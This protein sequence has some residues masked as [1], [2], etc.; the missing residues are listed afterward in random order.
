MDRYPG[1]KVKRKELR[2][3]RRRP[4]PQG[5]KLAGDTWRGLGMAEKNWKKLEREF[6]RDVGTTRIPV[7]GERAGSDFE[8]ARHCY[9][10]KCRESIPSC[11]LIPPLHGIRRR[12]PKTI[13]AWL[14]G[15]VWTAGRK[16]KVGVLVL[17]QMGT[18]RA[19]GKGHTRRNGSVAVLRLCD[20]EGL[21]GAFRPDEA[22]TN[23]LADD[24]VVLVMR[25]V[26]WMTV[27]P[28][29]P[30][31]WPAPEPVAENETTDDSSDE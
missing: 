6:A 19:A 26:V 27:D 10:L 9:Q 4:V 31:P 21:Y 1:G 11:L 7:T 24:T 12:L 17:R 2:W 22:W 18:K 29:G 16:G 14:A 3:K 20:W 13:E 5:V 15:V 25:W 28:H 30:V 23:R 8:T